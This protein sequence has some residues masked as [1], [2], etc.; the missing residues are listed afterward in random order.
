VPAA[1]GPAR[2]VTARLGIRSPDGRYLAYPESGATYIETADG[3]RWVAPSSG[4]PVL[5]SPDSTRI[6]WQI[7][8]ST[9][10]FDRRQVEIKV[11]AVDGSNAQTVV[12]LAGGGLADWFPDGQ[13]LLISGRDEADRLDYYAV[14]DLA[15]G[16]VTPIVEAAELRGAL[17]S[18]TGE[19]L[20]YQVT[21]TG[22]GQADGLWIRPVA[23]GEAR[24]AEVYGAYRWRNASSLLVIPL[25]PSAVA[26]R[27]VAIDAAAGAMGALTDPAITPL[28]IAGGDWALAP[29]GRRLVFVSAA[30]HNLWLLELPE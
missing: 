24:R 28:Q 5:F 29:D 17:L 20:A 7:A 4:R 15:T 11:A 19:W 10:N 6:A 13:R 12:T 21:F 8:Y 25:E 22:D 30:D 2:F 18:P 16:E 23:G 3:E 14:Y 9:V 27:L 1:G 26:Q